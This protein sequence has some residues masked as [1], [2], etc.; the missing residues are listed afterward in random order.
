MAT[1]LGEARNLHYDIGFVTVWEAPMNEA[2]KKP[3]L[4]AVA[5]STS[6]SNRP[7]AAQW[8]WLSRGL[9]QP[10]GKLPLF[11]GDGRRIADQTVKSCIRQG[12]AEPWFDNPIKPDWL[13]CKLTDEGRNVAGPPGG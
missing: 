11:D 3:V 8:R 6:S 5:T 2:T 13:V 9:D 4:R 1:A 10:G 12:W 7:T